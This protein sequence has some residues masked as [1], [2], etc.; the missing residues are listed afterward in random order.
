MEL[1]NT[2]IDALRTLADA[3][4]SS[5]NDAP[6]VND[7]FE[8]AD[9]WRNFAESLTRAD[10]GLDFRFRAQQEQQLFDDLVSSYGEA[11]AAN[12]SYAEIMRLGALLIHEGKSRVPHPDGYLGSK[13]IVR[14]AFQ[15]LQRIYG[16]VPTQDDLS[17][18]TY[19]AGQVQV[20]LNLPPGGCAPL[21]MKDLSKPGVTYVLEDILFMAGQPVPLFP[22]DPPSVTTEAEAEALF[23]GIAASLRRY[24]GDLLANKPGAFARLA[25]A[26]AERERRYVE[27]CERLY[28]AAD[29]QQARDR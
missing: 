11:I 19:I 14:Q 8:A 4:R 17:L 5:R 26:A 16:F 28:G 25:D 3:L 1:T 10:P 27:A 22:E 23:A 2:L 12:S 9:D 29:G 13:R 20:T 21:A 6:V 18:A 7:M 24:G 15:F